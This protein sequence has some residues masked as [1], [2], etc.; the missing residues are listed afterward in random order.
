MA[1]VSTSP[2]PVLEAAVK[3]RAEAH[4]PVSAD[5]RDVSGPGFLMLDSLR[6]AHGTRV[7]RHLAIDSLKTAL[8]N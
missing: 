6:D 3:Q 5:L 1:A 7:A 2:A 8:N 4:L